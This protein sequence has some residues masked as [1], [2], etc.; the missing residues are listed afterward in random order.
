VTKHDAW[1]FERIRGRILHIKFPTADPYVRLTVYCLKRR[2]FRV[3]YK[4]QYSQHTCI[5]GQIY[6]VIFIP[7]F[8]NV[9][10]G[11]RSRYDFLLFDTTKGST[12]GKIIIPKNDGCFWQQSLRV[13][14]GVYGKSIIVFCR[15]RTSHLTIYDI[16][17]FSKSGILELV[18]KNGT[19]LPL[20][21]S[22]YAVFN[23]DVYTIKYPYLVIFRKQNLYKPVKHFIERA[24]DLRSCKSVQILPDTS[25]DM[26]FLYCT[27]GPHAVGFTTLCNPKDGMLRPA[28]SR[29]TNIQESS[30]HINPLCDDI[31]FRRFIFSPID[32]SLL[33]LVDSPK[34]AADVLDNLTSVDI[35]KRAM[36]A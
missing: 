9:R 29:K 34:K 23:K 15:I 14:F 8:K 36:L 26:L 4:T 25:S 32:G 27:P 19:F 22:L 3:L 35:Y 18:L 31:N 10:I 12:S 28:T 13:T 21:G 2:Y 24:K 33:H 30:V 6:K 17:E 1:S 16:S 11:R 7:C 20:K 5:I